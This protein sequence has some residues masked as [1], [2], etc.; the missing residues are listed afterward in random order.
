MK[1]IVIFDLDGTLTQSKPS[2]FAAYRYAAEKMGLPVPSDEMLEGHLCGDL[3]NNIRT[4]FGVSGETERLGIG[5]YREKYTEI[6]MGNVPLF[7]GVEQALDSLSEMGVD[8]YVA[9]M[10]IEEVAIPFIESLGLSKFF[11]KVRGASADGSVTKADMILECIGDDD[12]SRAVM[13]GDCPQDLRASAEAGVDFIAASYG[14]GL[15]VERCRAEH[16]RYV[17][18]IRKICH[19]LGTF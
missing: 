12:K 8:M 13:V 1:D 9:T 7:P 18:D 10:K 3:P 17:D 15:P 19:A 11:E 6:C 14:Y 4:L 5:L 16:I 2:I